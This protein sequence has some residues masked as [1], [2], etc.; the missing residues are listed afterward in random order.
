M[1]PEKTSARTRSHSHASASTR[2]KLTWD[3]SLFAGGETAGKSKKKP[4]Q[5]KYFKLSRRHNTDKLFERL[6]RKILAGAGCESTDE[7]EYFFDELKINP[8]VLNNFYKKHGINLIKKG[9]AFKHSTALDFL[10]KRT[11]KSIRHGLL[12]ADD[13]KF[14]RDFSATRQRLIEYFDYTPEDRKNRIFELKYLVLMSNDAVSGF[15]T[16]KKD[17]SYMTD[18]FKENYAAALKIIEQNEAQGETPQHKI[19][20]A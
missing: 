19:G 8:S 18:T 15:M 9:L 13:Y 20:S 2:K 4:S 11:P 5:R 1:K 17:E 6:E 3:P 14:L 16:S 7:L 10:L 12:L